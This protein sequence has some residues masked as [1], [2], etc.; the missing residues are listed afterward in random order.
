MTTRMIGDVPITHVEE[1]PR[2]AFPPGDLLPD[3]S[4][5]AL[6][7]HAA[8]LRPDHYDADEDLVI[9]SVHSW[10]IKTARH[11]ILVDT[12]SGNH[13]ERP[14]LPPFHQL[15]VPYM[16]R[17]AAAGVHPE[18]VDFVM[19]THLHLDHVGWNTRL[20]N[21]RWVPTFPNAKYLFSKIEYDHWAAIAEAG[22]DDDGVDGALVYADSILPV[23]EA[24]LT[25]MV[26]GTHAMDDQLVI[27]PA[28][29]HTPGSVTLML[30]VGDEQALFAGDTL[31]HPLQVYYPECNSA[32][33]LEPDVA[34][35]TRRRLLEESADRPRL[36]LPAHFAGSGVSRVVSDGD[37]F[38]LEF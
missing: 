14:S 23:V 18:Q 28:P 16:E 8:W 13:K 25:E 15:D 21:G 36:F 29:G 9:M 12:C 17:L 2:L 3:M 11:T 37:G 20:E 38:A 5:E 30:T 33:C 35:A 10:V 22:T 6:D 7:K 24:G 26:E 31:H 27:E 19:C 1:I 4:R 34:R 32:F